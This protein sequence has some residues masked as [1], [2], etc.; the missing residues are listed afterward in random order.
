MSVE[1]VKRFPHRVSVEALAAFPFFCM[2][3]TTT[4]L[5]D[6]IVISSRMATKFRRAMG[7]IISAC[8]R[9][10]HLCSR[11]GPFAHG[12]LRLPLFA[13]ADDAAALAAVLDDGPEKADL[14]VRQVRV[15]WIV[16]RR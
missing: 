1:I 15:L 12:A 13:L 7:D 14:S 9:H 11:P 3:V 6:H 4:S 5:R 10:L 8:I 16:E 2:R